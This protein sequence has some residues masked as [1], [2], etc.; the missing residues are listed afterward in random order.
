VSDI[1]FRLLR[2]RSPNTLAVSLWSLDG[3][4]ASIAGV[5]LVSD[6]VFISALPFDDY[7]DAPDYEAQQALRPHPTYFK[8]V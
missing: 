2:R 4:G 1:I 5:E 8:P 6:G 7:T 3:K